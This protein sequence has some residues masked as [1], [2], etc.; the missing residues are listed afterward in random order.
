[1]KAAIDIGKCISSIYRYIRYVQK[2]LDGSIW[3][4]IKRMN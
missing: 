3:V 4:K 1:M 2:P